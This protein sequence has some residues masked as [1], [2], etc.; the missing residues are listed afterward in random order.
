M[1]HKPHTRFNKH[2]LLEIN[3]VA[4]WFLLPDIISPEDCPCV[5]GRSLPGRHG[6]SE[7][8]WVSELFCIWIISL[9]KVQDCRVHAEASNGY[10]RPAGM[11]VLFPQPSSLSSLFRS[12]D[13]VLTFCFIHLVSGSKTKVYI[14]LTCLYRFRSLAFSF[15]QASP[16]TFIWYSV[17]RRTYL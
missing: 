4:A 11:H 1:R 7:C 17:E 14:A 6:S 3:D 13:R 5:D 2:L 10:K 15:L 12:Q 9:N 8:V 16:S